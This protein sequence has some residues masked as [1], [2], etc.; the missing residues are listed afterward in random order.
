MQRC[1]HTYI[2]EYVNTEFITD[3]YIFADKL[4]LCDKMFMHSKGDITQ[5]SVA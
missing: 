3:Y 4:M 1:S 5:T 2:I